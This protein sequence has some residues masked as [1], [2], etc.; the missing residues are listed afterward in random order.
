MEI[1]LDGGW[2]HSPVTGVFTREKTQRFTHT[3][4]REDEHM[5]DRDGVK[6]GLE[7]KGPPEAKGGKDGPSYPCHSGVHLPSS[8]SVLLAPP[9][10][11][12][13]PGHDLPGSLS[14]SPHSWLLGRQGSA[15]SR[16]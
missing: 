6:R 1:I 10:S 5:E 4:L 7:D 14:S 3:E 16:L 2:D 9:P 8:F 13:C 12:L 15:T 11:F